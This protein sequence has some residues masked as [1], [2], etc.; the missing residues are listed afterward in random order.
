VHPLSTTLN[1]LAH[2]IHQISA[3]YH[4][5][6]NFPGWGKKKSLEYNDLQSIS[7]ESYQCE[8]FK[9]EHIAHQKVTRTPILRD[10]K[11]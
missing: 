10:L 3:Q 2:T 11:G 8:V 7:S 9:N 1:L 4:P 6:I 5:Q